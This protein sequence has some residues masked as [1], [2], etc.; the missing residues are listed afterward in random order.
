[1]KFAQIFSLK[2]E[3]KK[4]S[5]LRKSGL[6]TFLNCLLL[7]LFLQP[8]WPECRVP[9][10][11]AND[12]ATENGKV[13]GYRITHRFAHKVAKYFGFR[14]GDILVAVNGNLLME[15]EQLL[16]IWHQLNET[17]KPISVRFRRGGHMFEAS[18]KINRH[19]L[20]KYLHCECGNCKTLPG[21]DKNILL[22]KYT[23]KTIRD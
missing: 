15:S 3:S 6:K 4:V 16:R 19:H 18:A 21:F 8:L 13:I 20:R 14:G 2:K 22:D 10:S 23:V 11:D 5:S 17:D 7:I 12:V 1:V 9:S